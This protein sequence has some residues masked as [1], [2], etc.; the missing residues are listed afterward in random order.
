MDFCVTRDRKPG[1]FYNDKFKGPRR[2]D[3]TIL[4]ELYRN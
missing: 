2:G 1:S 3:S 4:R